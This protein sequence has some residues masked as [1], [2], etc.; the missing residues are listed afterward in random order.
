MNPSK[1]RIQCDIDFDKPGKQTSVLRVVHSDNNTPWGF[2]PVPIACIAGGTVER[3]NTVLLSAGNHGDEYEGQIILRRLIQQLDPGEIN[4]RIIFLPAL[5]YSAV[6]EQTR[7]SSIDGVNMN[8]AFPGDPNTTATY[9]IAH[10]VESEI[11]PMCIAAADLHS[12]GR[13]SDFVPCAYL[14]KSGEPEF[15]QQKLDAC[16]AFAAPHT[17]V[18]SNTADHRSLSAACDR[19]EV[20]MVATELAGSAHV[21]LDATT[22]GYEGVLRYLHHFGLIESAPAAAQPTQYVSTP[23]YNYFVWA[24]AD[25]IFEPLVR[26]GNQVKVGDPAGLI[27]PLNDPFLPPVE[28]TFERIGMIST[29]HTP[30]MVHRGQYVFQ[31]SVEVEASDLV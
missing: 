7:V 30:A 9:A 15:M 23:D 13:V 14:R 28:L 2:I 5:N 19:N 6:L 8:R 21:R 29:I 26:L 22:I 27:H 16:N 4:G 25:G 24:T 10:Y 17:V 31:V 12:G 1:S 11:L 20:I 3:C 18:V